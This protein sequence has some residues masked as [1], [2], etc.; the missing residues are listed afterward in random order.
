M[1]LTKYLELLP[2]IATVSNPL[3]YTTPIWGQPE[4]TE[5]VFQ[6]AMA[7][8]SGQSAILIQDYPAKG[9]DESLIFYRN[10]ALAFAKAAANNNIPA[11]ICST[12]PENFDKETRELL[13]AQGVAPM[14]GIHEALN[15][16]SQ[17]VT[18]KKNRSDILGKISL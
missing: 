6:E 8:I 13:I 12:I 16:I 5:P 9:L 15:A 2:A 11:A 4:K 10:D 7:E 14:Q 3:D 18:W 1:D 17:A